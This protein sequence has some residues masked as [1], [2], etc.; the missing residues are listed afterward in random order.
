MREPVHASDSIPK[1]E[2]ARI[3]A[4]TLC[5]NFGS[6]STTPGARI[7]TSPVLYPLPS[8]A[9]L[10]GRG[11]PPPHRHCKIPVR[12]QAD[13]AVL[14]HKGVEPHR[15]QTISPEKYPWPNTT[16]LLTYCRGNNR[17]RRLSVSRRSIRGL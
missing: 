13:T 3:V 7:S 9:R 8:V 2:H 16:D 17:L 15:P 4:P 5:E 1:H 12:E 11:R 10:D 6:I 14:S